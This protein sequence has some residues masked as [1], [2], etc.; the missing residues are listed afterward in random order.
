MVPA[1]IRRFYEAKQKATDTVR[2][3]GT[4]TPLR[5]F[6]HA[7]DL[8][9]A[10]VFALE[11]W[12][13]LSDNSPKDE[14]GETLSFL[15]VGTGIDLSIR[16]LAEKTATAVGF[17]GSISWDHSK[18]DGTPKKQL[19]VSRLT[20]MGWKAQIELDEGLKQTVDD[21]KNQNIIVGWTIRRDTDP[22]PDG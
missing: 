16:E 13:A 8:G 2:C 5:E 1:L 6:L 9:E 11:N 4:G 20:E 10:C 14:S 17:K 19:D 22:R 12:S 15:N 21:F 3:W 7:D 18:P